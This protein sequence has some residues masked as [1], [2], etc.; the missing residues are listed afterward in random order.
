MNDKTQFLIIA[1]AAALGSYVCL[2]DS[3]MCLFL[4]IIIGVSLQAWLLCEW[5]E[6]ADF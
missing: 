6:N 4:G 5:I 2:D 3:F 1:A